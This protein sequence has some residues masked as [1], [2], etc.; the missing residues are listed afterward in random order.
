MI[1]TQIDNRDFTDVHID[2]YS[3][4]TGESADEMMREYEQ[5]NARE[6]KREPLED[7]DYDM[8]AIRKGLALESISYL[9]DKIA[10]AE[11]DNIIK[12]I[13]LIKTDSPRFYNY[14]TDWY[15]AEYEIDEK[16][17][18]SYIEANTDAVQSILSTYTN[19][20]DVNLVD[21]KYHAG[22]CHLINHTIDKEDY[23]MHMWEIETEVYYENME[24]TKE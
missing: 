15:V 20:Y 7:I 10:D 2:T 8:P 19:R 22:V 11:V 14:T 3:M 4:L 1:K 9:E 24:F 6:E 5:D 21:N 13:E 12:K 18:D 17:M 23:N 16:A